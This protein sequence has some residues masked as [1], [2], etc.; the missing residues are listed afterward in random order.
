MLCLRRRREIRA[1]G[2]TICL[3]ACKHD[4]ALSLACARRGGAL[5]VRFRLRGGQTRITSGDARSEGFSRNAGKWRSSDEYCMVRIYLSVL[6]YRV[7]AASAVYNLPYLIHSS[8][9]RSESG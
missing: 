6:G 8:V 5:I 3:S 4:Y 9:V 2:V 1:S 7:A